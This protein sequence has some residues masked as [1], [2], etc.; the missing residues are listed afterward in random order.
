MIEFSGP[1]SAQVDNRLISLQLVQLRPHRRR[2]VRAPTA[3]SCSPPRCS[4]KKADPGRARQL[5][6]RH[7]RQHRHARLRLRAVRP[8]EPPVEPAR[9]VVVLM[10]IT[11]RNLLRQRRGRPRRFPRPRRLLAAIGHTVLISDYFEY[12]RLS[13]LSVRATRTR[14]SASPWASTTCSELFDEKYYADLEGGI[15]ENFG[16]LFKNDLK[17][18]VYPSR[19]ANRRLMTVDELRSRAGAAAAVRLLGRP[20]LHRAADAT[21]TTRTSTS[22]R[23]TCSARSIPTTRSGSRWCRAKSLRRSRRAACSAM[24]IARPP[25]ASA[26]TLRR[27][28][29]AGRGLVIVELLRRYA[30]R[31]ECRYWSVKATSSA[32]LSLPTVI[33]R[34]CLPFKR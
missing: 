2:D 3:R 27:A 4:Y 19:S 29:T 1:S 15:L 33:T 13:V 16:R 14:R 31:A 22:S 18:Y 26:S 12:Y 21:S 5:P 23:A 10:E 30:R 9:T 11:M 20:P 7:A 17:L 8:A 25:P 34:Y 32:G 24:P 28:S 6:A